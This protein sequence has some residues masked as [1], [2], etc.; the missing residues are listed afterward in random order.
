MKPR[1]QSILNLKTWVFKFSNQSLENL[2]NVSH[3]MLQNCGFPLIAT[4]AK[5]VRKRDTEPRT[6]WSSE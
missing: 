2:K 6:A 5:T 4:L 1:M 3:S